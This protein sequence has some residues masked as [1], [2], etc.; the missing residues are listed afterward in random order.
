[1][2][3]VLSAR[4]FCWPFFCLPFFLLTIVLSALLRFKASSYSFCIF[5]L[6]LSC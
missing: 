1:L 2:A 3:I 6:V 4:F 5:K